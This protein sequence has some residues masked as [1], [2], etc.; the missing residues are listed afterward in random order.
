MIKVCEYRPTTDSAP[1]STCSVRTA[2]AW[3]VDMFIE[4]QDGSKERRPITVA[5]R[6][7]IGYVHELAMT[8][9]RDMTAG[10]ESFADCGFTIWAQI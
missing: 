6:S 1:R 9:L 7:T 10:T 4:R 8:E 2:K 5:M 3:R